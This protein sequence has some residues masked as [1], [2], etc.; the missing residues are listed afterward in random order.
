MKFSCKPMKKLTKKE[1][2]QCR[3]GSDYFVAGPKVSPKFD[4]ERSFSL[5]A[6]R[7]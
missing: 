3:P 4:P 5:V 7:Y 1:V 2:T 6:E